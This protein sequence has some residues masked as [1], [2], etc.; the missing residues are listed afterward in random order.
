MTPRYHQK[1]PHTKKE[2]SWEM[3]VQRVKLEV[4]S[5]RQIFKKCKYIIP[6][7]VEVA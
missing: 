5:R 7:K 4:S 6:W 3:S 1:D 2:K